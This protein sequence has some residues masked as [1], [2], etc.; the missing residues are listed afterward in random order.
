MEAMKIAAVRDSFRSAIQAEAMAQSA[1]RQLFRTSL[2]SDIYRSVALADA[3]NRAS[4]ASVASMDSSLLVARRSLTENVLSGIKTAIAVRESLSG[5]IGSILEAEKKLR[6]ALAPPTH[7]LTA[8]KLRLDSLPVEDL[9]SIAADWADSGETLDD[10]EDREGKVEI[11]LQE[12]TAEVESQR[13]TS[14]A[15]DKK[16]DLILDLIK[17]QKESFV[18]IILVGLLLGLVGDWL[19]WA[20]GHAVTYGL[21]YVSQ[22][23]EKEIV[24]TAHEGLGDVDQDMRILKR[25][26]LIRTSRRRKAGVV[27]RMEA[28]HTVL[29][30]EKFGRWSHVEWLDGETG[31]YRPGWVRSKLL[32]R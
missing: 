4:L 17:R 27:C 24:K 28:G 14:A 12:L 30:I 18:Q 32:L 22:I 1:A 25:S 9:E 13:F 21:N 3:V 19:F 15:L 2:G 5:Q 31:D 23:S 20:G 16:L 7:A 10:V 29:L 26:T 11:A 6:A 8:M